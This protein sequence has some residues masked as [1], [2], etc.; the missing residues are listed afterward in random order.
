[1]ETETFTVK[2]VYDALAKDG[3]EHLRAQWTAQDI[4]GVITGACVLGQAAINLGVVP[5]DDDSEFSL[6]YQLNKFDVEPNSKW[7]TG[8][9][10]GSTIVLWNDKRSY[11]RTG[12]TIGYWLNTYKEVTAMAYDVLSPHFDKTITLEKKEWKIA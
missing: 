11:D 3:F 7:D 2:Q 4:H 9:K 12:A 10:A 8:D 6:L 1:M 5:S